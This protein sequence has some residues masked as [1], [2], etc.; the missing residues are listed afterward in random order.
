MRNGV[1]RTT[2]MGGERLLGWL[3]KKPEAVVPDILAP[4]FEEWFLRPDGLTGGI[5]R[6][7]V[8]FIDIGAT[9]LP[10][11]LAREILVQ[12]QD[13]NVVILA[14]IDTRIQRDPQ[15]PELL[16]IFNWRIN[17]PILKAK[18]PGFEEAIS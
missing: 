3:D 10:E 16:Q 4:G 17:L 1:F 2:E 9:A 18:I 15:H 6:P 11:D 13:D 7:T 8:I 5:S 12:S 14:N